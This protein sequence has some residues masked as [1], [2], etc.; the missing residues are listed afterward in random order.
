MIYDFEKLNFQLLSVGNFLYKKGD[1]SVKPRPYA[2]LSLRIFG[3]GKFKT[4]AGDEFVTKKNDI[5]YIP[6][7]LGY[8]VSY[9]DGEST[10]IHLK[11]CNY[12]K[13]EN[14]SVKNTAAVSSVFSDIFKN[15]ENPKKHN[16]VK[17][18]IYTIFQ[19]LSDMAS[20]EVYDEAF[21]KCLSYINKSFCS[22][23]IT[24]FDICR[25]GN[26]S[27]ATL[28]R[29]FQ[30]NIGMSPKQYI[31][32]KRLDKAIT[33]LTCESDKTIGEIS[34]LCGFEDSKYFAKAV[35][36]KYGVPPSAFRKIK[37]S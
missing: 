25:V 13:C 22:S 5:L 33:A 6:A 1:F 9:T 29:K 30:R 14:I 24:L 34:D 17:S 21:E 3:E 8:R 2:S 26:V 16:F 18:Q 28:R 32:K 4:T 11:D 23:K 20:K 31:L 10:V 7:G 35:K 19:L 36:K 27:E 37:N 15:C 12:E